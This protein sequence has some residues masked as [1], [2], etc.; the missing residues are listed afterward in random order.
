[1]SPFFSGKRSNLQ[2]WQWNVPLG[3]SAIYVINSSNRSVQVTS[4]WR[5]RIKPEISIQVKHHYD[6]AQGYSFLLFLARQGWLPFKYFAYGNLGFRGISVPLFKKRL[7]C[8]SHVLQLVNRLHDKQALVIWYDKAFGASEY[9][10]M[11]S[12]LK[13]VP[14]CFG[15]GQS[16][17]PCRDLCC[18]RSPPRRRYQRRKSWVSLERM[19]DHQ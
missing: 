14:T 1:M 16:L 9:Q 13:T 17:N 3:R 10:M 2:S 15:S 12:H 19:P 11:C 8:C 4:S 6:L 18:S 5:R 7:D